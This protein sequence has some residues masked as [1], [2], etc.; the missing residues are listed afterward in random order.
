MNNKTKNFFR[1]SVSIA[2]AACL[3][4]FLFLSIF[5][6]HQTERTVREISDTY[7]S[8]MSRQIQQKF[9][10]IIELR[11]QQVEGII[12]RTEPGSVMYGTEMMQELQTS[13]E[14]R[15]FSYLG[16]YASDGEIEKIYGGDMKIVN[17]DAA[18]ALYNKEGDLICQGRMENGER[19]LVLGKAAAYPMRGGKT[20]SI[21]IVGLPMNYLKD[22]LFLN[23][24]DSA[25]YSHII[26]M[27]GDFVVRSEGAFR[28]SYFSRVREQY[29][30]LDGKSPEDYV[31]ELQNAM[32]TNSVYSTIVSIEGKKRHVYCM[33]LSDNTSWY[34]VSA[35]PNDYMEGAISRLDRMRNLV[36]IGSMSLILLVL[37][38]IFVIY[39]R[40]SKQQIIDLNE[41]TKEAQHANKAKSEFLS[42]MS[43][44]IRSPMNAIIGMTEI[45]QRN[46]N[47]K[48]RVIDCLKKVSLSSKHL[49]GLIND[50]LDMSKIESGK[51][52]L[53]EVPVSLKDVMDDIV[54]IMQPQLKARK[55]LFDIYIQ[56]IVLENVFCD[57]VR[58]NQVLINL[59][60]NAVKF[61]PEGGR[62]DVHVFQEPSPKGDEFIR[63][64]FKVEDNGI[65]MSEEFQKKIWD[66]FS[67]EETDQVRHIVGAG[68]GTS[69]T[70]RIV[71][72][73]GGTIELTSALGEGSC[74]HVILDLR[75]AEAADLEMKLPEWNIL[76]VDDNEWLCLSAV[77][78]LE[79]LGAHAEWTL[80]GRDAVKMIAER[81]ENGDDYH[82]VLVDWRMPQMDGIETI[83]EI[84]KRVG[85]SIPIFLISAYDWNELGDGVSSEIEGF[86]A[87]PL[88][89]SRLYERLKQYVEGYNPEEDETSDEV[90]FTGKRILLAEDM[91][92]N[93]E[94]ASEILSITGMEL[95]RAENG[96]ICVDMFE[97]SEVGYYDAI[98][99]DIRMPVMD[100]YDATK[101]IRSLGRVDNGLPIIAM[102][103]DV[104]SDDAQHCL[105]CG[106]NAHIPKPLDIE[107][108]M[109]VLQ[110]FLQ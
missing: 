92:I 35:M 63:T 17:Q 1:S 86:I 32:D 91:D 71:E 80:D 108:C 109:R 49:L 58:L 41:A 31:Q 104:F 72:L 90:D 95:E 79:E 81:H 89:K 55:Q 110:R 84:R 74:F 93:W 6:T 45:A 94:V 21:L 106:M 30:T 24:E 88:F 75:R 97:K 99:M 66:T 14:I 12:T 87:K 34:L 11:L 16:L 39:Y 76:V 19:V 103:A 56:K 100:G 42:S 59:L 54:N 22:V 52:T 36:V 27:D 105:E 2:V 8:E 3:L 67:R 29:E 44:D 69:I 48:D 46:I 28:E 37:G 38:S 20:S 61:T 23:E 18:I 65:G 82:F 40:M 73:M 96:K 33:S 62:V 83:R 101:A 10:A 47:D 102:T 57:T 26:D 68:L 51:M 43:H 64:H 107:E 7:M 9:E 60:T 15:N 77:S 5:M 53:N 4:V 98:L 25:A 70:K 50:V 13:A 85:N 78:N